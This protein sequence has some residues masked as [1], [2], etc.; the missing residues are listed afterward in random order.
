M[1]KDPRI[2]LAQILERINRIKE[3]TANGKQAFFAEPRTQDAV[4]RR[5]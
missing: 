5:R 4:I 2:Y 3:Y 1:K